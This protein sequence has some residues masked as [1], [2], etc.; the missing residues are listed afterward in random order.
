MDHTTAATPFVSTEATI[1]HAAAIPRLSRDEVIPQAREELA[2]FLSLLETLEPADWHRPTDCTLWSV[3]DIVAHQA[4]HVHGLTHYS[5]ILGQFNPLGLRDYTRRGINVLDTANQKQ[6]DLRAAWT[7]AQ[8]IIEMREHSEA[9]FAG[10]QRFPAL[11]R[12]LPVSAPGFDG[13]IST[14]ELIDSI[15]TRDMWMHRLD[16]CRAVGRDMEQTAD[17]DGR[18]TALVVRDLDKGMARKLGGR[19]ALY[20][21]TGTAGGAWVVGRSRSPDVEIRMSVA[22]FH[23]LASGR[24]SSEQALADGMVQVAGDVSLSRMALKHTVVLY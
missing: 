11:V 9:S 16:I 20:Q 7:P 13:F 19:S 12:M 21:L 14:G 23:R 22:D 10:R 5:D 2:R 1:A 6:V 17:H 15:F 8:L 18:I 4:S 24:I 3:K